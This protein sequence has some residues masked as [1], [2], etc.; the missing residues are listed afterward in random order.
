MTKT[1]DTPRHK[2]ANAIEQRIFGVVVAWD[3][4]EADARR[5]QWK[6]TSK[7]RIWDMRSD[8]GTAFRVFCRLPLETVAT[9]CLFVVV[10]GN[11]SQWHWCEHLRG[12]DEGSVLDKMASWPGFASIQI[13]RPVGP[14]K[15]LHVES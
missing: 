9:R 11:F 4:G 10:S 7:R 6:S 12:L 13:I 3:F 1:T 15:M 8:G 2:T 5:C 14:C